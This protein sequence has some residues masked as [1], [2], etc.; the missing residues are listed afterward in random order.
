MYPLLETVCVKNGQILYPKWHI[1]R[2]IFSLWQMY[3][4][5][6]RYELFENI[7]IPP[8][9]GLQKLRILYNLQH[10]IWEIKPYIPR[11]ISRLKLI[12]ISE[13]NYNLKFSDRSLLNQLYE[14]R[15]NCD[16]ILIARAGYLTDTSTH[17]IVLF[18]G[19]FWH[20]PDPPLLAGTSRNRLIAEKQIIP[21]TIAVKD[22]F[23]N[24]CA[25]K[26]INCMQDFETAPTINLPAGIII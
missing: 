6:P 23:S 9:K 4:A 11:P 10:K 26:L 25:F 18:D 19:K 24:Y 13:L 15:E 17:N 5:K 3:K 21:K 16:D 1:K 14:L 20:T 8:Q 12:E 22:L 7:I 2:H